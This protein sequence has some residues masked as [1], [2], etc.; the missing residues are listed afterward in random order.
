[1]K[2]VLRLTLALSAIVALSMAAIRPAKKHGPKTTYNFYV[3]N[4]TAWHGAIVGY[5]ALDVSYPDSF[6]STG[7]YF[8][9]ALNSASYI[10]VVITSGAPGTHTYGLTGGVSPTPTPIV[11]SSG[12]ATFTGVSVVAGDIDAYIH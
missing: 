11:S 5:G 7:L 12:S 3:Q 2:K 1:M 8:I 6:Y 10:T 9:K 4:G